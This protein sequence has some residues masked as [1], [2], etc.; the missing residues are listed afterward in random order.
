MAVLK[1]I[2][3]LSVHIALGAICVLYFVDRLQQLGLP[4]AIY[5]CLFAAVWTIYL[6]DHKLDARKEGLATPRRHF[7][8]A[9]RRL[10]DGLILFNLI[11]GLLA[12]A[13]IPR[14]V[15]LG[16]LFLAGLSLVY[17]RFAGQLGS[18]RVKE[19]LTALCYG[20]GVMLAPLYYGPFWPTLILT[21]QLAVLALANL[22]LFSMFEK[23]ADEAEGFSS[24]VTEMGSRR[25]EHLLRILLALTIVSAIAFMVT[26]YWRFQLFMLVASLIL[27]FISFKR[28]YF[29]QRER[30]R[31]FGDLVFILPL[32]LLP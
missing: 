3:W 2:R 27:F 19:L 18:W 8:R 13:F 11:I 16:G 14:P 6:V 9:S 5:I 17:L 12:M 1:K 15:V 7:H 30:Y 21:S 31:V 24:W 29:G 20:A 25:S 26:L 28:D 4:T 23:D 10:I 22:L 32:A